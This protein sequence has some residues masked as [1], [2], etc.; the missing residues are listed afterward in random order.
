MELDRK[1]VLRMSNYSAIHEGS[2]YLIAKEGVHY[3]VYDKKDRTIV[4]KFEYHLGN[5]KEEEF[6]YL[7]KGIDARYCGIVKFG[8]LSRHT[9]RFTKGALGQTQMFLGDWNNHTD[10]EVLTPDNSGTSQYL[11]L[12]LFFDGDIPTYEITWNIDGKDIEVGR[13]KF[14]D[15]AD[16]AQ[17]V[18]Y[19]GDYFIYG[20]IEY[21]YGDYVFQII[22]NRGGYYCWVLDEQNKVSGIL[23][24][25]GY[26]DSEFELLERVI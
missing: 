16:L 22:E 13:I 19:R 2:K 20:R 21:G 18:R 1:A 25:D 23:E 7:M 26:L 3:Y 17:I 12:D 5:E 10:L 14:G 6:I 11:T 24:H 4:N 9:I 15:R 8:G